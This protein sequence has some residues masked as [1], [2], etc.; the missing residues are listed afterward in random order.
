M[1]VV[2]R[3]AVLVAVTCWQSAFAQAARP[4]LVAVPLEVDPNPALTRFEPQLKA[5]FYAALEERSQTLLVSKRETEAA[6]KE[7]KRQDFRESDEGL[8][9]LAEKA[10]TLYALFASLE[11]TPQKQLV[12]AGRVVRRDD[13]KLM[14]AA[15]VQLPKDTDTIVEL[16]RPLAMQF[17]V[18]LGLPALPSSKEAAVT[19]VVPVEP[20]VPRPEE[21]KALEPAT[22]T[23]TRRP[24]M[25]PALTGLGAGAVCLVTGAIV[26]ATAGTVR[27]DVQQNVVRVLLDDAGKVAGVRTSQTAGVT[28]LAVGAALAVAGTG[29]YLFGPE[30]TTTTVAPINGGAAVL[31]R[32]TFR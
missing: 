3:F 7:T 23:V 14:K 26:F 5:A 18:Q 1:R 2:S 10:G 29:L 22:V 11:Y 6:I 30:E 8:A 32:G 19:A 25:V 21:V 15:R 9:R 28:L 20:V 13:G 31:M 24:L 16:M 27:T 12:L 17:I 4:S